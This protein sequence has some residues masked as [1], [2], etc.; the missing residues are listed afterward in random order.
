MQSS[1]LH[2][3]YM[4][5]NKLKSQQSCLCTKAATGHEGKGVSR[6]G[7]SPQQPGE[8]KDMLSFVS[9]TLFKVNY[10]S[11]SV[12]L[13]GSTVYSWSHSKMHSMLT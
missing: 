7:N 8:T 10:L 1:I 13:R 9:L 6:G 4:M 2:P 12:Q 11:R 5:E 3:Y